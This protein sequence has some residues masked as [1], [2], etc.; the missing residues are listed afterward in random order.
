M[1]TPPGVPESWLTILV[2]EATPVPE[3]VVPGYTV[4]E[5]TAVTVSTLPWMPPVN[6]DD[7]VAT[8]DEEPEAVPGAPAAPNRTWPVWKLA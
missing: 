3:M 7:S 5:P 6:E 4:P 2:P 8:L 1:P